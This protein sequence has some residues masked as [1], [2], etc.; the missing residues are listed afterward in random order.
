MRGIE[1][2]LLAPVQEDDPPHL[3]KTSSMRMP[4]MAYFYIYGSAVQSVMQIVCL[5][6]RRVRIWKNKNNPRT[7]W[8][9]FP[10]LLEQPTRHALRERERETRNWRRDFEVLVPPPSRR[11]SKS[12]KTMKIS[13]LHGPQATLYNRHGPLA[14]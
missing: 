8:S 1:K 5:S 4:D 2:K 6:F 10:K 14:S 3:Q 13:F 12:R 11:N 7:P 9:H